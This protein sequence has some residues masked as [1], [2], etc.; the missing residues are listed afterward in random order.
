M[1]LPSSVRIYLATKH[2][3]MRKGHDGLFALVR[4]TLK[5]DPFSGHLFVFF[6]RRRNRIKILFFDRG[7]FALFYKRLE[8]GR[9]RIPEVKPGASHIEIEAS[10]LSMILD[11]YDIRRVKRQKRWIPANRD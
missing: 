4:N 7:G 8:K 3:D 10:Q 1:I 9:F 11:G 5:L 2:S 6:S